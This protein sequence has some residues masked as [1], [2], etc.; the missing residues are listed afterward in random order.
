M[1][2]LPHP[3][4]PEQQQRPQLVR[5]KAQ[6]PN[7][8]IK[9]IARRTG[10]GLLLLIAVIVV[11]ILV[12]PHIR[13]FRQYA[14]RFAVGKV[15]SSLGTHVRVQDFAFSLFHL[16]L[17]LYGIVVN[18]AGLHAN[19]PLLTVDHI[20]VGIGITSVF[21]REWYVKYLELNHPVAR[22]L[23]DS[24]GVNNLPQTKQNNGGHTSIF[25]LGVRHALLDRGEVYY[26]DRKSALDADLHDLQF[27]AHFDTSQQRYSGTIGY[28]DGHLR[29][30]DFKP[31]GHNLDAEFDATPAKFT[32]QRAI[33]AS[34]TS[35]IQLS[36]NVQNYANPH[37]AVKYAATVNAG[38][39]RGVMNNPSLPS[40]FI[41]TEGTLN[42]QS[43][44]NVPMLATLNLDGRISSSVLKVVSP[45]FRG[46]VS[47]IGARYSLA[48][49][50]AT[51]TDIH[52]QL[53]G[54]ELTGG[55]NV[56]DVAGASIATLHA[57]A[58]Q[59]SLDKL[60]PLAQS[61]Q[62]EQVA[63]AGT[64]NGDMDAS[65]R[66]KLENLVAR[67]NATI[68]A[69]VA[70]SRGS[71]AIPVSAVVHAQYAAAGKRISLQ[72]SY[73]RLPQ[74]SLNLNG[75]VSRNSSLQI[76]FQSSNLH[77]LESVAD[78]LDP[79][80]QAPNSQLDLYG[81]ASFTG[82]MRGSTS[83]PQ[84]AG[85]LRAESLQIK[86][87]S[88][89]M[90]RT[91]V[92]VNP[93]LS[94][95]RNGELQTANGGRIT[96]SLS[97]ALRHWNFDQNSQIDVA[98]NANQVNAD[99]LTK[100]AG[101]PVPI[102]GILSANIS[103]NGSESSPL[104]KGKI[105][106]A[107]ARIAGEP[108]QSAELNFQA[109]KDKMQANLRLQ[110]PAGAI[111]A[112]VT[113]SP[114]DQRYEA[115]VDAPGIQLDKLQTLLAKNIK[116]EG[117]LNVSAH[118]QGSVKNPELTASVESPQFQI[119]DQ[120]LGDLKLHANIANHV[121]NIVLDAHAVNTII[122]AKATVNTTGD[123]QANAT[124][125][126]QSIPLQPLIAA[127]SPAEAANVSGQTELHFTL[128]GP[129]KR[130]P[131]VEAHATVP[132]LQMNYTDKFHVAAV[133]PLH[134]DLSRG[135]LALQKAN[136]KG[137]GTDM[138]VQAS[139]PLNRAAPLSLL[140]Q[141]TM[142]LQ[143]AQLFDPDITSSGQ[144]R[145]DINS[146]GARANPDV[147]GQIHIENANVLSNGA[148]V[149]LQNGNGV[150]TLTKDRLDISEFNGSVGGGKVKASGGIVYRPA[151][152]FDLGLSA[153]G[154]RVPYPEG[155]REALNADL[156]LTGSIEAATLA[157][158]V[159][160]N[161]LWFTPDFDLTT[162]MRQF[163]GEVSPPPG[164][165]FSQNLQLN[166]SVQSTSG[167]NLVSRQLTLQGNANLNIR[168]TAA[169]PVILG[170]VNLNNGDLL[171]MGNR[172]LLQGGTIDF[173]NASQTQPVLNVSA[174]TTVEQYD[175]RLQFRG[176]TD[177]LRTNY[178]S[179]PSLPPSDIINLLVFGKTSEESAANPM[180]GNLGAESLIAS[181][182]SSQVTS[183]V[184]KIAGISRLSVDPVLGGSGSQQNPG[185]RITIQ[186]RVTGN[187]FVT[188]ST[189]VTQTQNQVIEL[190]Y[191]VSPRVTVSGT[192]DQN[193]GFGFDTR[194]KKTW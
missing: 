141:G 96:F 162:F 161:Q 132:V 58:H 149:G 184:E 117:V 110:A 13:S 47:D 21:H 61:A 65:W 55:L 45:K 126:T 62:L 75:T 127:F 140:A 134:I 172:Y 160:I 193:G 102:A 32:L 77:E 63:L 106:L 165:G 163:G 154:I 100:L 114:K 131:E 128:H 7:G 123:Y 71:N 87:S 89:R 33:L 173:A 177:H 39:F 9:K 28:R 159:R 144:M 171:F 157:G 38:E 98:L 19:P 138:Q 125:D 182:I 11:A 169:E 50:N 25:Q 74:S 97:T 90:L 108:V 26:N 29:V 43:E 91:D 129:L 59:I 24:N 27:Q 3:P 56:R 122:S 4:D 139:I 190:Q 142:D 147:Q 73:L 14:L 23:V 194:I 181:Q 44:P 180:P 57:D 105:G 34:G 79:A 37:I 46:N 8:L 137:T 167:I 189:D 41:S 40:G 95:L 66:R 168:G 146:F 88:W 109:S 86:G 183:R 69:N 153:H 192:R 158:Q 150:L 15:Q 18:G 35:K 156:A 31:I 166:L 76:R 20:G 52:A 113:Y 92:E 121:A 6:R 70:S 67:T 85:Q 170:R 12:L 22:V 148:P 49:G 10:F 111:Q 64:L 136:I 135:V 68:Q 16:R 145:F 81:T 116:V 191:N 42:Y 48:K 186:Q 99:D 112:A 174:N 104:G 30:G 151:V 119:H 53:L 118:G 83:V 188:F 101:R 120:K 54:G 72:Q 2:S 133:A 1:S 84:L 103:V 179:V 60:K 185:A 175:I 80:L 124:A 178:T 94:A 78:A 187:I 93:S 107:K 115:N 17:N 164:Q 152:R 143:I 5:G 36:G 176:P 155:V 51:I 82:A 130:W